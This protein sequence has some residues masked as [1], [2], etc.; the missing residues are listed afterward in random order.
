MHLANS[1]L[2]GAVCLLIGPNVRW[3][4]LKPSSAQ[5]IYFANHASHF[6][7][8]AILAALPHERRARTR[9]GAARDYWGK[10]LRRYIATRSFGAVLVDRAME[11]P[12][13]DP[14]QPL[15]A[16]LAAGDSLIIFPEGTRGVRRVPA[17]FREGLYRLAVEFPA[18][19]LV[20]VYLDNLRHVLPKGALVPVPFL[21]TVSLGSPLA[22]AAGETCEEFLARARAA[23]MVL[24]RVG[25]QAVHA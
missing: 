3:V 9:V 15:R 18:V 12:G 11:N 17:R 20:P 22:L 8:A 24:G 25:E 16:V 13:A 6:D 23:V 5:R 1:V 2:V 21:C 19:E 10:G 14:L 4:G 7:T